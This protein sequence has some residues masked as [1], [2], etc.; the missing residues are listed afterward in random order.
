MAT[1]PRL[2]RN[3]L[4][5]FGVWTTHPVAFLLVAVYG[6]LW[7]LFN[8]TTLGWGGVA[9]LATWFMTLVIQRAEH[10]DTQAIHAKLDELLHAQTGARNEL[11]KIDN[12]D[13]EEIE[14]H[15]K[16]ARTND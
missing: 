5:Q 10:R 12:K 11:T 2:I 3:W 16:H 6:V 9:V 8:P 14:T 13:A 15:R 4:T 7:L 1:S